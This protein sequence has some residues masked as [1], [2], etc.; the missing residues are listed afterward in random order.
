MQTNDTEALPVPRELAS[1]GDGHRQ[2]TAPGGDAFGARA[3][4]QAWGRPKEG[5]TRCHGLRGKAEGLREG[6]EGL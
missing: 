3:L 5:P 2:V 4:Y 1:R 6:W